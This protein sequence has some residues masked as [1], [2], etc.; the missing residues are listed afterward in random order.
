MS[1]KFKL[2]QQSGRHKIRKHT[3]VH[4]FSIVFMNWEHIKSKTF[5]QTLQQ[6]CEVKFLK[7][8][9]HL[10]YAWSPTLKI[11]TDR[12]NMSACQPYIIFTSHCLMNLRKI[13][14]RV[15]NLKVKWAACKTVSP[16]WK[17]DTW[18]IKTK[19]KQAQLNAKFYV[20]FI[21]VT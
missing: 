18:N 21:C 14:C 4:I 7:R 3:H 1:F 16:E 11:Q 5:F 8:C 9:L 6:C 10:R 17:E 13:P 15:A 12:Q 19:V 2:L 20:Y